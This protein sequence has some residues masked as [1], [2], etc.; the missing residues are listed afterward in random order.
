MFSLKKIYLENFKGVYKPTVIE[1]DQAQL[2]ILNGPN[3]FGK[4]TVFDVVEI[5]LRGHLERTKTYNYVTK[6]NADHT[7]P[8]YQ[9]R[10]NEDVVLKL[11]LTDDGQDHVIV[12]RLDRTNSGSINGSRRFRPDA[13]NLLETYYGADTTT[14]DQP[15]RAEAYQ[16]IEQTFIDQLFFGQRQVTMTNLYPLFNYLQQEDNIYF[17]K[18]DEET[19]AEQLNFLF[20]TQKQAHE[21]DQV[22]TFQKNLRSIKDL[23]T[24]R[25]NEIGRAEEAV[26]G[27]QYHQLYPNLNSRFD[28]EEPYQTVRPE[29]LNAIFERD[30][31]EVQDLINFT[32]TFD[33]AE[34]QKDKLRTQLNFGFSNNWLFRSIVL[35]NFLDEESFNSLRQKVD[36]NLRL[37]KMAADLNG[38]K[39]DFESLP[40]LGFSDEFVGDFLDIMRRRQLLQS[41]IGEIGRIVSELN[42]ARETTVSRYQELNVIEPQPENCPLCD[43]HLGGLDNLIATINDKTQSLTRYNQTQYN[44]YNNLENQIKIEF[45]RPVVEYIELSLTNSENAIDPEFYTEVRER[46]GNLAATV[47]FR[48]LLITNQIRI[49]DLIL[50]QHTTI[51]RVDENVAT[52]RER[53]TEAAVSLRVDESRLVDPE[54][55]RSYYNEMPESVLDLELLD[56]KLKYITSRYNSAKASSVNILVRR[57]ERITRLESQFNTIKSKLSSAIKSYKRL[58]IEKIK[59]PFY[60]Y[61]GKILQHY[62]QGYGIFIDVSDTTNRVRFLTDEATDHDIIHQ[63]SS[64]QLAVVSIA[65][66]LALNKVYE[67]PSHFKFLAIDDPIQTLDDL[68]IHSFIELIRHEFS[69]YQMLISTHEENVSNYLDYRFNKFS[70]SCKEVNVQNLFYQNQL[71]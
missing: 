29:D 9:N 63:L 40:E 32:R 43:S 48:E 15:F 14:F 46:R 31:A 39:V 66:C 37:N 61:S 71:G 7:K 1:L 17:L 27:L 53:I 55:F 34:Y 22:T 18:K 20:Q 50:R 69:S 57:L 33:F 52:L 68:N 70:L 47:R 35:F 25:I 21:L 45:I 6:K 8:F 44:E 12:K 38:F 56:D 42:L 24:A 60:I 2:T 23:L 62:Q 51:A 13:W 28:Q 26:S 49:E 65:F 67:T 3:G 58:M 16:K 64:G 41:Q 30:R 54:I 5:C 10:Q 19:K 36:N 59:V 11:W 4:T